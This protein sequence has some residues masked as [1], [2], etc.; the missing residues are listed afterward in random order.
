MYS[1]GG[2]VGDVVG[3]FYHIIQLGGVPRSEWR[4]YR[5][6]NFFIYVLL[7]VECAIE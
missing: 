7:E 5:G 6:F 4:V 3:Y 2:C 1:I